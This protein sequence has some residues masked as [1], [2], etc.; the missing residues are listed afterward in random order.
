MR[1]Q[2]EKQQA[3]AFGRLRRRKRWSPLDVE[4]MK[5]RLEAVHVEAE[6]QGE[7]P[8]AAVL[9]T[10][11]EDFVGAREAVRDR[12]LETND[13]EMAIHALSHATDAVI[14]ALFHVVTHVLYPAPNP[15]E[16]DRIALVAV[17]G[18]GRG[19]MAPFSDIDL[20]FLTA[21][22]RAPRVE[23]VIEGL[24]YFLWDLG[25][26]VGQS[27]R[28][29]DDC[30]RL[31]AQD[32]TIRTTLV[33]ARLLD[34]DEALYRTLE[35]SFADSIT[36]SVIVSFMEAKLA[37]AEERRGRLGDSR[38][39]LEPNIKDGKGG[40]RDLHT[41]LWIAKVAYGT[42]TV[43]H[44]VAQDAIN[45]TDARQLIKAQKYLWTLRCH[46]H[47]LTERAEERLTFDVQPELAAR[48]GYMDRVSNKA[49]ERFMKH[50]FTVAKKMGDLT[51]IFCAA[52]EA[53]HQRKPRL[54][55]P[56]LFRSTPQFGDLALVRDRLSVGRDDAFE[57]DPVNI[58]RLFHTAMTED[59]LIH[60]QALRLL[61]S[62]LN[63]VD[64]DLRKDPE[65]NRLF[66]EIL[67]SPKGAE[68]M[69]RRMSEAGVLGK[70]IPDFGRISAQMQFDMYHVFT[71]DEHTLR[72]VGILHEIE[73]G[74][75][76]EI[77]PI[78]SR[79][80]HL[81]QSR[82]ALHLAVFLHDIGKGRQEEHSLV[83]E[84]IAK[85]LG[86]R[87]GLTEEETET[88]AW[89][90][91][92][93]LYMSLYAFNRD[94]DDPK[95]VRDFC[96]L[97]K[98]P[99]RLRLLLVLTVAD[100]RATN[101]KIWNNWKATLLRELYY[102]AVEMLSGDVPAAERQRARIQ[103]QQQA[104]KE[105]LPD[106][107]EADF[108]AFVSKTSPSYWLSVD[109][110]TQ[111]RHARMMREATRHDAPLLIE[112]RD[113]PDRD[114]TE[115][116]VCATD[117]PGLFSQI[118]GGLAIVGVNVVDA[119]IHTMS[120]GIAI[121]T[122][123]VQS[124]E[125]GPVER[126]ADRARIAS[127]IERAVTGEVWLTSELKK[128]PGPLPK[129]AKVFRVSPRVL[130]D[131]KASATNT[132]IEVNG[133]DRPGFLCDVTRELKNLGLQIHSAKIAT[134]GEMAVDVFYVKDVFGVKVDRDRKVKEIKDRLAKVISGEESAWEAA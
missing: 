79:V 132:V 124:A 85:R 112:M 90:V 81:V 29:V 33:D 123:H 130:V 43:D 95:T 117:H 64:N 27:S 76:S 45:Q 118:A 119:R 100:I 5:S 17:G 121:D 57:H 14:R 133:L 25:L 7:D 22:R 32:V 87:L 11:R 97:V 91:R 24:L 71:T 77:A 10:A 70:F 94:V 62:S 99:E 58:L 126:P 30:L 106:F 40:L 128:R 18:Y 68:R 38:Y 88:T 59:L 15:S 47:W 1:L 89:L 109:T 44:L 67:A 69:L 3:P 42:Q 111:A 78:A 48:M 131:N 96:D 39:V 31:A 20:L 84:R 103:S 37:E 66:M 101:E 107:K 19:E 41:L 127:A 92:N 26:K 83:G 54:R 110:E 73:A 65:A 63:R 2:K 13:G 115:V 36:P 4:A 113:I 56:S 46:L 82:R 116:T 114:V 51:R 50:Y 34:G 134:Y 129:R 60:P 105:T 72:A 104:L 49:V 9:Q 28:T 93:H 8:R 102:R 120:H 86:P 98:S 80:V 74:D 6:R 52:I 23:Q 75:L 108:E 125:A 12:F 61:Q 21:V 16:G 35:K 122:L 53:E 55:L